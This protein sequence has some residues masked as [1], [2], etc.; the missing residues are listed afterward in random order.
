MVNDIH[1]DQIPNWDICNKRQSTARME[2]M[3]AYQ[4]ENHLYLQG[5]EE[6]RLRDERM[7]LPDS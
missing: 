6:I 5:R 3:N 2:R 7:N 1:V 4:D